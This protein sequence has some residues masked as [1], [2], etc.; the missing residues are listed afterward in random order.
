MPLEKCAKVGEIPTNRHTT[1]RRLA[2]L[3]SDYD[4]AT[5]HLH[6][7]GMLLHLAVSVSINDQLKCLASMPYAYSGAR[8]SH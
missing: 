4:S 2:I 1:P 6:L 5:S 8:C 3:D 7:L